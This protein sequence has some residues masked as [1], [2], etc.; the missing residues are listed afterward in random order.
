MGQTK[1]GSI[2]SSAAV[3]A[4]RVYSTPPTQSEGKEKI[5]WFI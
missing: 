3:H 5:A 4:Q 1:S 2:V